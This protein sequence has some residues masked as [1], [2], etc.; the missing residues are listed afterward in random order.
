MT[1]K[2]N[3]KQDYIVVSFSGGKDSTAMLLKMIEIGERIDEVIF[4]D[5]YKEYPAMYRHVEKVRAVAENAGI[6]FTILKREKSFDYFFLEY[7]A[8]RGFFEKHRDIKGRSW[9]TSKIR[10]CTKEMKIKVVQNYLRSLNAKYNVI[11][12]VGIAADETYRINRKGNREKN[13]RLP[14]VEWGM[15][16]KDCLKYC[17][18]KG[19]DWEG[20]YEIYDRVSCWCCPLQ[21]LKSLRSLYKHFP[22]FWQELKEMDKKTWRK[23]QV[24][25]SVADLEKRFKFEEERINQGLPIKGKEF[26][27]QL[28]K[29]IN[30]GTY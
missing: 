24:N 6:K 14:L 20:L 29:L 11:Q 16:E 13:K 17:Y 9:A 27:S 12:C 19:Y 26:Y 10:W 15:S 1:E 25:Y 30:G 4:C 18:D 22:E 28:K 2:E 5:T 7:R 23:F 21:S 8:S 3:S